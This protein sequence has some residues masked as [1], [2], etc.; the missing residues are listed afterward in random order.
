MKLM[1]IRSSQV[2]L[3]YWDAGMQN[4]SMAG[5]KRKN[6]EEDEETL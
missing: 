4:G 6:R 2:W 5:S 3:R 1:M